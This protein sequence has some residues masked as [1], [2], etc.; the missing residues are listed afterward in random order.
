[1]TTLNIT[2]PEDLRAIVEE[3]IA[4][5]KYSDHSEYVR[6]LIR[7]DQRRLNQSQL[8]AE[9]L[10]RLEGQSVEVDA[11][12]RRETRN[13]FARL[14]KMGAKATKRSHGRSVRSSK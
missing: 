10:R 8:E 4:S 13:E 7:Q 9:L 1:M 14:M 12:D 11:A 3:Q 2:L 6:S 5:G